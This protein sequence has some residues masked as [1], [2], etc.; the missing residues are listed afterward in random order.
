M[1]RS[2]EGKHRRTK[3]TPRPHG[4][5]EAR[6]VVVVAEIEE[7]IVVIVVAGEGLAIGLNA[8]HELVEL[9]VHAGLATADEAALLRLLLLLA[10]R[11]QGAHAGE[12][13]VIVEIVGT[14]KA[15]PAFTP[16]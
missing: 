8:E 2:Q 6:V 7:V 11:E 10:R 5:K 9:I 14:R 15:P 1:R 3:R 16:I 4:A 13:V 12:E